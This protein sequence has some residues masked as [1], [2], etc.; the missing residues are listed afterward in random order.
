MRKI[1]VSKY[2]LIIIMLL[3]ELLY[4]TE[5]LYLVRVRHV[6]A[7]I[8]TI[9]FMSVF[10]FVF[11]KN[12]HQMEKW[13]KGLF[14][15]CYTFIICYIILFIYSSIKYTNQSFADT[16]IGENESYSLLFI[17]IAIPII[18]LIYHNKG[19]RELLKF[20][21]GFALAV[22][23]LE[24]MQVIVHKRMGVIFLTRYFEG[25]NIGYRSYGL[26]II[27]HWSG[28]FMT[29][30][31]FYMFYNIRA[32]KKGKWIKYFLFFVIMMFDQIVVSQTRQTLLILA[33]CFILQILLDRNSRWGLQ[34][35][36]LVSIS[37]IV[38]VCIGG[39]IPDFI[40][41]FSASSD[42][43]VSTTERLYSYQ[44]YWNYFLRHPIFGF[45]FANP[46]INTSIVK[47]PLGRAIVDDVGIV[48]HLA[49]EGIFVVPMYIIPM[50]RCITILCRAN[51]NKKI[52]DLPYYWAALFFVIAGSA[53]QIVLDQERILLFPIV[54]GM[55]EYINIAV[56]NNLIISEL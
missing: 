56:K 25:R 15:E 27:L 11:F 49:K 16:L 21:N 26:R 40:N 48:G 54:L 44:Y 43:A 30:Y 8:F 53:T 29:L 42:L 22:C 55:I 37:I 52:P 51:R 39:Y 1:K 18:T 35:K 14:K 6:Y 24:I 32:K 10:Y 36:I 17:V 13:A 41:S 34:K 45:G 50:I 28:N 23:I 31:N 19:N 4:D 2:S 20:L 47:G 12:I 38:F 3:M 46:Q 9:L 7:V 33:G 5:F